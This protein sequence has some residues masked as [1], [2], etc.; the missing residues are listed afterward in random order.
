MIPFNEIKMGDYVTAAYEGSRRN[1]EVIEINRDDKQVCVETDVQEFWYEPEDL[2][3]IAI[4]DEE[5]LKLNFTKEVMNDG[6]VKYKKGAFRLVIPK[7]TIFPAWK[8][9]IAKTGETTPCSVYTP[10]AK[11]LPRDDQSAPDKCSNGLR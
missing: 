7:R 8:C 4:S 3:P 11:P 2:Y 1:G 10:V 6:V 9:G 5:M